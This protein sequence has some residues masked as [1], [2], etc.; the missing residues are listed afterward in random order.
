MESNDRQQHA[1]KVIDTLAIQSPTQAASQLLNNTHLLTKMHLVISNLGSLFDTR[2]IKLLTAYAASLV[3]YRNNQRSGVIQNLTLKE[4]SQRKQVQHNNEERIIISCIN[5]KTGP[6][7][8][9]YL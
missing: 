4:F 9:P 6:Q 7:V 5:H 2:D 3:L 1:L 8:M